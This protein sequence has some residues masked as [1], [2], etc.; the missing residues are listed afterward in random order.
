MPKDNEVD[1]KV[2]QRYAPNIGC[3][4]AIDMEPSEFGTWISL[5][6]H[7]ATVAELRA[8]VERLREQV[9]YEFS[10]RELATKQRDDAWERD[11]S[12]KQKADAAERRVA[13]ALALADSWQA[14]ADKFVALGGDIAMAEAASMTNDARQ[15]RATLTGADPT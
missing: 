6:D 4:G 2:I 14:L 3:D 15:L 5:S 13:N 11:S 8:E 12:L 7:A 10:E 1:E 9:S